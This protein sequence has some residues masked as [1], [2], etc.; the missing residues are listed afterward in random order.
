V[1]LNPQIRTDSESGVCG[2]CA[3]RICGV[4]FRGL[5]DGPH[6]ATATLRDAGGRGVEEDAHVT[7]VVCADGRYLCDVGVCECVKD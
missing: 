5:P 6:A 3:K 2:R 4:V 7:F 1:S